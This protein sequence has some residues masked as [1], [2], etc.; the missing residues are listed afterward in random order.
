MLALLAFALVAAAPAPEQPV[1][2]PPD[3]NLSGA[4]AAL[5]A[6]QEHLRL[7][8]TGKK[9]QYGAHRKLALELVNTAISEIDAGLRIA[10]DDAA[11][12]AREAK[13][14]ETRKKRRRR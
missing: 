4:R 5:V 14:A 2:P 13:E 8:D 1:Q 9:D 6:A 3:P 10:A 12:K 7:A 11:R